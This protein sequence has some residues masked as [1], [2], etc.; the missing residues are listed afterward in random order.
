[1]GVCGCADDD[2]LQIL[3]E[4]LVG[5]YSTDPASQAIRLVLDK[6]GLMTHGVSIRGAFAEDQE[7][8]LMVAHIL[9]LHEE[10]R[11]EEKRRAET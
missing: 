1:M 10:A 7:L 2:A 6:C 5:P 9:A 11:R 4:A 3:G 8:A